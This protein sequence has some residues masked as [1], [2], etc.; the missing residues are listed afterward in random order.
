MENKIFYCF[1]V[2]ALLSALSVLLSDSMYNSSGGNMAVLEHNSLQNWTP[3][4][5]HEK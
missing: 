2:I 1:S 3:I 5:L 4:Y